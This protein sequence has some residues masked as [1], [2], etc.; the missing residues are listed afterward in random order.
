MPNSKP[1]DISSAPELMTV[2]EAAQYLH[3]FMHNGKFPRVQEG[4]RWKI[5]K[6]LLDNNLRVICIA[7]I[8]AQ[9]QQ[10]FDAE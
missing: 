10:I 6:D 4:G 1:E 3:Y 9:V 8:N 7:G 2:K 5:R